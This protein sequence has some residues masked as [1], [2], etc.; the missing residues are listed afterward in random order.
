MTDPTPPASDRHVLT[1]GPA[2][3]TCHACGNCCTGWKVRMADDSERARVERQAVELGVPDPI[4]DGDLRQEG[5]VCVFL[6]PDRLCRI[7]ARWGEEEKPITCQLFPRRSVRAEDGL[8]FGVDP[9]C[10]STWRSFADGPEISLWFIPTG[11]DQHL[12]PGLAA[13]ER[14]L[15]SLARAPGMTVA[16]FASAL[17]QEPCSG[18][19]RFPAG[20]G[21]RLLDRCRAVVDALADPENG[22]LLLA[23]LAPLVAFLRGL[24]KGRR[25]KT[26]RLPPLVIPA[27]LD[28]IALDTLQRTLFLRLGAESI[29][30]SG[31]ALI[32]LAGTLGCALTDPRPERFGP[33]LAAWSR[34]SRLDGFWQRFAPDTDTARWVLG[35]E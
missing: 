2:R 3:H 34:V 1:L 28:A 23:D 15:V 17:G 14:R 25:L 5:G 33:A 21:T 19:D 31:H 11:K 4:V 9:G 10:S 24:D 20:M 35:G 8:R 16:R 22:P 32:A 27:A 6:G 12:K 30:P 18:P 29:P 26:A 7:H 13:V